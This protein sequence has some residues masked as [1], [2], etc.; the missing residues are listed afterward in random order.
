MA[1]ARHPRVP[2][3]AATLAASFLA[4]ALLAGCG[5][6]VLDDT[7]SED[8][9]QASLED[10]LHEKITAVDCPSD[11]KV[12]PGETFTCTVRFPG[13]E[14]ATA[15]LKILNKDADVSLVGFKANQ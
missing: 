10:S 14:Q 6:T 1:G 12:E 11:Q 13:G 3:V 5:D 4:A 8:V 15:T 9:V 2:V 7:K